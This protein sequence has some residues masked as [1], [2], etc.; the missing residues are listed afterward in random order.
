MI[1]IAGKSRV[2]LYEHLKRHNIHGRR[3][4]PILS[5][6]T[7][8]CPDFS[9]GIGQ[10]DHFRMETSG[11]FDQVKTHSQCSAKT[12]RFAEEV[13]KVLL[14]ISARCPI[15][16]QA[17]KPQRTAFNLGPHHSLVL[18]TFLKINL[19]MGEPSISRA[20]VPQHR[21]RGGCSSEKINSFILPVVYPHRPSP[22]SILI[23]LFSAPL[24][25]CASQ[26]PLLFSLFSAPLHLRAMPN[27]FA[28]FRAVGANL[29]WL[30]PSSQ[31][32]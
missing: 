18:T 5:G 24:R 1:G 3:F 10:K 19:L 8:T 15:S 12:G 21:C 14:L 25:L 27:P 2:D 30:A 13:L 28:V 22:M 6:L 11:R 20:P 23:P 16:P 26:I 7:Q 4:I 9:R 29:K 32:L 31:R 17:A